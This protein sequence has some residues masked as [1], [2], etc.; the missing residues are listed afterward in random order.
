MFQFVALVQLLVPQADLQ[1]NRKSLFTVTKTVEGLFLYPALKEKV[2]CHGL[3]L[4]VN[5][6]CCI[7][8]SA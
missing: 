5:E 8:R 7:S 2:V 4:T 3:E 1:L 6:T